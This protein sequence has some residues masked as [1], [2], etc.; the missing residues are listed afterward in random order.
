MA[1]AVEGPDEF[2]RGR[3]ASTWSREELGGNGDHADVVDLSGTYD[4]GD[5]RRRELRPR[6]DRPPEAG[7]LVRASDGA[8]T[9]DP[10][11]TAQCVEGPDQGSI[12]LV[13]GFEMGDAVLDLVNG[14][15]DLQ[16]H[17][18]VERVGVG[19]EEVGNVTSADDPD[20]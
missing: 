20:R 14:W 19:V 4:Q 1:D 8:G 7:H 16:D 5:Q 15:V 13:G 6:R 18:R 10:G 17:G 2:E 9:S 3:A 12:E 11:R